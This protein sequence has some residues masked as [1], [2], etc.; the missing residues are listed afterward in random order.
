MKTLDRY[1]LRAWTGAFFAS[2]LALVGLFLISDLLAHMDDFFSARDVNR[3]SLVLRF[4]GVRLPLFFVWVAPMVSLCAMM[5]TLTRFARS[6]EIVPVLVSGRSARRFLAPAFAGSAM[7]SALMFCIDEKV[8]PGVAEEFRETERAIKSSRNSEQVVV[9]DRAGQDWIAEKYRSEADTM[10]KVL[11]VRLGDDFRRVADVRAET[12]EWR[13]S[14]GG[15]LLKNGVETTYGATQRR[16]ERRPIPPEGLLVKSDMRP[17]DIEE[18]HQ[19]F[20]MATLSQLERNMREFP[21]QP[22]WRV[23]W[24]A[25]WTMPLSNLVLLLI[26]V[27]LLMKSGS[28]NVFAGVAISLGLGL[29]FFGAVLAFL[30]AGNSGRLDPVT[31]AWFPIVLFGAVGVAMVDSMAT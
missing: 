26:G 31:A 8:A 5:L 19:V 20:R 27:P 18:S 9:S 29:V 24:H 11:L 7:V 25:K 30:D 6:N 12:A 23:Q 1:V 2:A 4:Y 21:Y 28:R 22:F 3:F 16:L 14:Q 17:Q 13:R 15:W 10:D